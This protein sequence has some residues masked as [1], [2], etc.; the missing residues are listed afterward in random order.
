MI[1]LYISNFK[2]SCVLPSQ[3]T[4]WIFANIR[5][6]NSNNL[7]WP[8][9]PQSWEY[10]WIDKGPKIR[11]DSLICNFEHKPGRNS[12]K[13]LLVF[14]SER[15][16]WKGEQISHLDLWCQDISPVQ[17]SKVHFMIWIFKSGKYFL[18]ILNS[19][20]KSKFPQFLLAWIFLLLM[21]TQSLK[22]WMWHWRDLFKR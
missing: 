13:R 12:L 14:K 5:V 8:C 7:N 17:M 2:L 19:H 18:H 21:D 9:P 16:M 3:A 6:R 4:E 15:E 1:I 22:V 11:G 20:K 10:N